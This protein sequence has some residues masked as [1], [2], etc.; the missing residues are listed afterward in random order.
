MCTDRAKFQARWVNRTVVALWLLG[1]LGC[2]GPFPPSAKPNLPDDHTVN[3]KSVFHK[4]GYKFP[5]KSSSG[6]SASTCHHDDL[7][8]G[9]AEVDGRITVAPSCFQCHQTLWSDEEDP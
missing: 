4:P 5:Y 9:M 6:C 2:Q 8:G 7:D 3:I 1:T